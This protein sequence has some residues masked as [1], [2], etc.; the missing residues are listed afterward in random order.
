ML[1][2]LVGFTDCI[3]LDASLLGFIV[4]GRPGAEWITTL[5]VRGVADCGNEVASPRG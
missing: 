1:L 5:S 4:A 3:L 2:V